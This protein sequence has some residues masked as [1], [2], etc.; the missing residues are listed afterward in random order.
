MHSVELMADGL[1]ATVKGYV[2]HV[3]GAIRK[4]LADLTQMAA[5]LERRV[6]EIP[7]GKDAEPVDYGRI[8]DEI[9]RIAGNKITQ[10]DIS[11]MIDQSVAKAVSALPK[12]KDG[13]SVHPDTVQ[14]MIVKEVDRELALWPKPKDGAD[15]LGFDDLSVEYDGERSF[16]IK[17]QRGEEIKEFAFRI[18]VVL[19]RGVFKQER[20]YER[21]D[22][23]TYGGS[24]WIA[25]R[26]APEGKPGFGGDWRLAV[27]HGR[28]G[29]DLTEPKQ[30]PPQVVRIR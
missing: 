9:A 30:E 29:K 16:T 22:G 14:L 8:E 24:W 5:A 26:D 6:A 13:E 12:V 23:V 21:S 1:I 18:P 27:K 19:D 2:D 4:E 11:A 7:A 15:G 25:Q 3:V 17:F 28:D 20:A 10:L